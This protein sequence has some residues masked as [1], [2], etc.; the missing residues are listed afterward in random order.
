MTTEQE[1]KKQIEGIKCMAHWGI[2]C[3]EKLSPEEKRELLEKL[4]NKKEVLKK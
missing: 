4:H 2:C 3:D 1:L